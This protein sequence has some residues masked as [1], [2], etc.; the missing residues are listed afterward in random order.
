MTGYDVDRFEGNKAFILAITSWFGGRNLILPYVVGVIGGLEFALGLLMVQMHRRYG[1]VDRCA[2]SKAEIS[3]IDPSRSRRSSHYSHHNYHLPQ[4]NAP[5]RR[6]E[7]Q[8]DNKPIITKF[9]RTTETPVSPTQQNPNSKRTPA[10]AA[11]ADQS[12]DTVLEMD[13]TSTAVFKT[14]VEPSA[15]DNPPASSTAEGSFCIIE[16]TILR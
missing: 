11:V 15:I 12:Y 8:D 6:N 7:N 2:F 16:V 10:P 9:K 4:L 1:N 13:S 14:A 3:T 5:Q